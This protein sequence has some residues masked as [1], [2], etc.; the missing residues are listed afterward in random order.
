MFCHKCA[1]PLPADAIFCMRCGTR[2][3][4]G[5][6]APPP[7]STPAPE[8]TAEPMSIHKEAQPSGRP[9]S[10][11]AEDAAKAGKTTIDPRQERDVWVG[12][13]SAKDMALEIAGLCGWTLLAVVLAS[14]IGGPTA[15]WLILIL[16]P[17]L[18]VLVKLGYR[19]YTI[20]YRLTNQRFFFTKGLLVTTVD[21]MELARIDD[22]TLEQNLIGRM[23]DV[24]TLIIQSTDRS[25]P[26]KRLRGVSKPR[27][28]KEHMRTYMIQ[29]RQGMLR[30]HKI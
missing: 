13:Y 17:A 1:A 25:S 18:Y 24:G 26:V 2:V 8:P 11:E 30:I 16:G 3:P 20:R 4:T 5:D 28:L 22:V 12:G 15:L 19:K 27:E 9:L 7:A 10:P 6:A 14:L 23:L 21:E 29:L